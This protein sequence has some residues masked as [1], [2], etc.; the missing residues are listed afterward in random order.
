MAPVAAGLHLVDLGLLHLVDLLWRGGLGGPQRPRVRDDLYRP[1]ARVRGLVAAASEARADR[2][3]QRD[4]FHRRHGLLALRQEREPCRARNDHRAG[5]HH[6]VHRAP[7]AGSHHQLPGDRQS[8]KRGP[9]WPARCRPRLPDGVLD[10]RRH[11]PVHHPVRDPE[12]RREGAAPRRGGGHRAGG[13]RQAAGAGRRRRPGDV[14]PFRRARRGL[15]TGLAGDAA[16]RGRVRAAMDLVDPPVGRG[17]RVP[18]AGVPGDRGRERRRDPPAHRVVAVP[19][20]PVPAEPVRAA[21]RDRRPAPAAG[22]LGPGHVRADAADGDRPRVHCPARLPGRLL[23]GDV[24]GDHRL[25]RAVH[26][27]L[28]PHH[29]ADR[30]ADEVGIGRSGRRAAPLPADEPS[31][32]HLRHAAAG[33]PVLPPE[34]QLGCARVDRPDRVRRRRTGAAQSAR[35]PVLA[36]GDRPR[37][38][39]RSSVRRRAV[40]VHPVPAELQGGVPDVGGHDPR[41]ALRD[42]GA[43][44]ARPLRPRR[45]R[46]AH[47]L[48]VLEPVG[49]HA[50]LRPGFART[51]AQSARAAAKRL[52]RGR[53][54]HPGRV[55]VGADPPLRPDLRAEPA[56]APDPRRRGGPSPL[57]AP[58]HGP[59]RST[60]PSSPGSSA[61]LPAAWAPRPPGR[62]S[63]GS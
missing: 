52:V 8:R 1:D 50:A 4:H 5:R 16:L 59:H 17:D 20:L 53:V 58:A 48:A 3:D 63:R 12:H 28:E 55:D 30:V 39:R 23:V 19:A 13:D 42:R 46:S 15:R 24:D 38:L 60:M 51:R 62:W 31:D 57:R 36:A 18:A 9:A 47:P 11:G 41:G 40:G 56:R 6:P 7:A 21:D 27:A 54:P 22:R 37:R 29:H 45:A 49:Q 44:A 35:R 43:P 26:D 61:G 25:H 2:P 33:V 14:R 34:R 10:R 32:L